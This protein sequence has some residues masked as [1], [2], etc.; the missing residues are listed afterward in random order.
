MYR[1][2]MNGAASRIA[3]AGAAVALVCSRLRGREVGAMA[4]PR[5]SAAHRRWPTSPPGWVW[6]GRY[7]CSGR[8]AHKW[9]RQHVWPSTLHT[10]LQYQ[11]PIDSR[12]TTRLGLVRQVRLQQ[13]ACT[14]VPQCAGQEGTAI[15]DVH[16]IGCPQPTSNLLRQQWRVPSSHRFGGVV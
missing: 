4:K 10:F 2:A 16:W 12:L 5:A 6:S 8:N 11:Q 9:E 3:A 7:G 13:Q 15:S 14:R 1:L